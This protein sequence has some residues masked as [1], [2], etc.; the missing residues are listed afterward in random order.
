MPAVSLVPRS[1]YATVAEAAIRHTAGPRWP[2]LGCLGV[3]GKRG[4]LEGA[5]GGRSWRQERQTV[6]QQRK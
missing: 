1:V 2:S 4:G 5:G 6:L 3:A